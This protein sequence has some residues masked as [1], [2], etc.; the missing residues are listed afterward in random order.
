M[1]IL[2]DCSTAPLGNTDLIYIRQST[3]LPYP[4]FTALQSGYS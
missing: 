2:K 4:L 3:S 1:M